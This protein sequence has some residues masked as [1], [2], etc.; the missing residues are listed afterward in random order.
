[1][2][3]TKAP[4]EDCASVPD[5]WNNAFPEDKKPMDGNAMIPLMLFQE[6]MHQL[7]VRRLKSAIWSAITPKHKI[8]ILDKNRASP[9]V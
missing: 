9:A 1:M 5:P 2:T 3:F 6:R 8:Y 7:P 4:D